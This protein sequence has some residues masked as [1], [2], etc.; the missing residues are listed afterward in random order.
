M[1]I[2][3]DNSSLTKIKSRLPKIFEDFVV[4]LKT[5]DLKIEKFDFT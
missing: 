3:G 4:D 2:S 5:E 1:S